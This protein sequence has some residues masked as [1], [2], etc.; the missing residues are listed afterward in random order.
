M[1]RALASLFR[2]S[3]PSGVLHCYSAL[4]T[5][6]RNQFFFTQRQVPDTFDGRFE[7]LALHAFFLQHRLR[8]ER[9]DA[10]QQ[11][12]EC[13]F[14]DM[15][16]A[17][18]ELGIGDS[19]VKRRVKQMAKAYHGR[20][21]VYAAAVT[22][23]TEALK[24]ALARNLYGTVLHGDIAVLEAMAAYVRATIAHL[25]TIPADELLSDDFVWQ[26]PQQL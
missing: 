5:A 19:G 23:G 10:A 24:T 8:H 15:D 11:L 18:R 14:S 12:S 20:L 17:L 3:T 1:L 7:L 13:F 4:V 21:Q 9:P 26:N 6:A 16:T 22:D 25:G 2:A